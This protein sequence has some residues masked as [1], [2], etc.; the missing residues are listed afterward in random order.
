MQLT[1]QLI[2][3]LTS[4]SEKTVERWFK[5]R[6]CTTPSVSNVLD[7]GATIVALAEVILAKHPTGPTDTVKLSCLKRYAKSPDLAAM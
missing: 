3:Q 5:R 1:N 4:A 7:R 2:A 6:D